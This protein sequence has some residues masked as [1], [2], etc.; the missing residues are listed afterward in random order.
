MSGKKPP[1]L[2]APLV[3]IAVIVVGAIAAEYWLVS[4]REEAPVV[5]AVEEENAPRETPAE[6]PPPPSVAQETP[7]ST[8]WQTYHGGP[9]LSGFTE[10]AL[11][12]SPV[13]L[14]RFQAESDIYHTPVADARGIYFCTVKGGVYALD[15]QG[16]ERWSRR[17]VRE[18]DEN[19]VEKLARLEA[20]LS[21]FLSTVLVG[22]LRGK[23]HALNADTGEDRWT[24][25]MDGPILGTVN[26]VT[27]RDD[28]QGASLVAI[29]QDDGVLHG[30]DFAT[31][32]G[33]WQAEA[34]DRCDGS[35]AVGQGR[36]VY[37]SCAAALHLYSAKDGSL[38]KNIELDADSQVASGPALAGDSIFSG[39]HS[40][41][42]FHASASTGEVL[43]VNDESESEVFSTPAVGHDTIVYGSYDGFVYALDRATG[44]TK[45]KLET[46]GLPSSAVIAGGKVVVCSDGLLLILRL[47]NG[48]EI[49]SYEV[50]DQ[51]TSPAIIGGMVVVGS[52]DGTLTAFGE[53]TG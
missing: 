45:W 2:S 21:C 46:K 48:E 41:R 12:D 16:N 25:D 29:E 51:I 4:P 37:G 13:V 19:G 40:G 36:I 11:P 49:W 50:S 52:E 18:V 7:V 33:L 6:A 9:G 30:I 24:Y 38:I 14:W 34:I 47:D 42:V 23:I 28:G 17:I 39:S 15:L 26:L 22:T 27:A 35:A 20:P 5:P 31:G 3:T 43:W 44:A 1:K 8:V 10:E 32:K 53:K